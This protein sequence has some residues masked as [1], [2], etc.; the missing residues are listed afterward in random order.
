MS[1]TQLKPLQSDKAQLPERVD[2]AGL[3]DYRS[4]KAIDNEGKNLFDFVTSSVWNA[5]RQ[6]LDWLDD[7]YGVLSAT[8]RNPG[9][10][11]LSRA[12]ADPR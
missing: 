10:A 6:L 2:V 4:F 9:R 1:E 11:G 3:S 7:S 5:R 12:V 8:L